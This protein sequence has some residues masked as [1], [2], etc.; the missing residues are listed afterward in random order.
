M[1]R[2]VKEGDYIYE[3]NTTPEGMGR[4]GC[5]TVEKFALVDLGGVLSGVLEE[6]LGRKSRTRIGVRMNDG[7]ERELVHRLGWKFSRSRAWRNLWE[8][9]RMRR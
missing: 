2:E 4:F 8:Y 3:I 1:L 5:A 6:L 9:Y 7:E